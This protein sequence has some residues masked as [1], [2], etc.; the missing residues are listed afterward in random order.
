MPNCPGPVFSGMKG[1]Q[2]AGSTYC[3][4]KPRNAAI[5]TT[6]IATMIALTKADWVMPT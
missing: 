4:P 2:L 5:T 3:T 6:L 1:V